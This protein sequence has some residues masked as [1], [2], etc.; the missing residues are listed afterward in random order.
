MPL[1]LL[2]APSNIVD[3]N[4]LLLAFAIVMAVGFLVLLYTTLRT[5]R[6]VTKLR[7][8]ARRLARGELTQRIELAGP[9]QFSLLAQTLNQ[10]ASQL[11]DRL[12]TVIQQRNEM[13]AVLSSMVEGVA[14]IDNDENIIS[15]NRAAS[16]LLQINPHHAIG[17]SIQEII[18]N[19]ALQQYLNRTLNEDQPFGGEVTMNI[20]D[21]PA[22][23]QRSVQFQTA[24][25]RDAP[26]QRIG[27]LLVLHDVTQLRRLESV[28]REFVANVSH[29]VRTPVAAIKAAVETLQDDE[30]LLDPAGARFMSIIG[31]Q[32][33]RLAAI[34]DDLLSLARIEEHADA[35]FSDLQKDRLEPVLRAAVET[36]MVKAEEKQI[37]ISLDCDPQATA[38]INPPLLEQAVINLID[39]AVKY[40]PANT[41][42][43][44]KLQTK[45]HEWVISVTDEGRGIEPEHLARIFERFY[46]TD[47]ARSR[48]MGGTGLGLSIVK[49]IA[50]AHGGRATVES[51]PGTGSHFSI[52]LPRGGA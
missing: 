11:D 41:Q 16:Q 27:A 4:P 12:S 44:V 43:E 28:R 31:R 2:Q 40:S 35:I 51:F 49:H 21:D 48:E 9:P 45:D 47:K 24:I 19:A 18:R 14:A 29:E 33:D 50:E 6:A 20:G 34:V 26:G 52:H 36:V 7:L 1:M 23:R 8:G 15:L 39:N 10:M 3:T 5:R 22:T 42:V 17:R 30:S 25:L 32:A 46:R 13:G 38:M 37:Q